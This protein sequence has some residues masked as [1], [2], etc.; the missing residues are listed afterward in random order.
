MR[1]ELAYHDVRDVRRL[2]G[3][4]VR[5]QVRQQQADGHLTAQAVG[6]VLRL[7]GWNDVVFAAVKQEDRNRG[8]WRSRRRKLWCIDVEADVRQELRSEVRDVTVIHVFE[9]RGCGLW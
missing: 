4:G 9:Q 5:N 7:N 2:V 8:L 1:L 3:F 6:Q